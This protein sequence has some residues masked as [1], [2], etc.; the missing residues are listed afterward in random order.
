MDLLTALLLLCILLKCLA[1]KN[2]IRWLNS[3]G[4]EYAKGM[5]SLF[6]ER[7]REGRS[8]EPE[9]FYR[10]FENSEGAFFPYG[11]KDFKLR[12]R[13]ESPENSK[14]FK[15]VLGRVLK[16]YRITLFNYPGLSLLMTGYLCVS[17]G[18]RKALEC[19]F[20]LGQDWH[21]ALIFIT[22]LALLMMNILIEVEAAFG[23]A[24]LGSYA[25]YFHMLEPEKWPLTGGS[26]LI[27]EMQ[28]MLGIAVIII[29]TGAGASFT[30]YALFRGFEG[31]NLPAEFSHALT[32][33]IQIF[34]QFVYFALTTF[35]TVGY[36]DIYAAYSSGQ[37]VASLMIVQGFG[38]LTILLSIIT[39]VTRTENT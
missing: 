12:R 11:V 36:G 6:A 14:G 3:H 28:T 23:Y 13:I 16:V 26:R 33:A 21:Y 20:V 35:T 2:A 19:R 27:L 18:V 32:D 31:G 9:D 39:T 30:S 38:L 7:Q 10:A 34:L 5:G 37:L 29:F 15:N 4:R 22:A 25:R 17:V 24:T 1:I 8:V